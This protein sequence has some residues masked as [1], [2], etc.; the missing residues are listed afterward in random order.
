[1][2]ET[3]WSPEEISLIHLGLVRL[4]L[5]LTRP[6]LPRL[7]L[8]VDAVDAFLG[9]LRGALERSWASGIEDPAKERDL[10]ASAL[11]AA[12][13]ALG[14][15]GAASLRRW[16]DEVVLADPAAV[17][18]AFLWTMVLLHGDE[19]ARSRRPPELAARLRALLEARFGG[20]RLPRAPESDWD[21]RALARYGFA[22]HPADV[23]ERR[24]PLAA[25][26]DA[27]EYVAF[28]EAWAA[29][30]IGLPDLDDETE[31]LL[32]WGRRQAPSLGMPPELLERPDA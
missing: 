30:A 23:A 16:I 24:D 6:A 26:E 8:R 3:R 12:E 22:V 25:V 32:A 14:P 10:V 31:R 11:A 19:E 1:M 7:G 29:A 4:S 17:S 28:K 21:R 27:I 9:A 13:E 5:D 2:N 20:P 18:R 15:D